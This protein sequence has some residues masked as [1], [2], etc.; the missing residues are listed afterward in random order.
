M[1]SENEDQ[2]TRFKRLIQRV[3]ISSERA[4]LYFNSDIRSDDIDVKEYRALGGVLK[5]KDSQV[6]LTIPMKLITRGGEKEILVNGARPEELLP[7][8]PLVKALARGWRWRRML[9][10]AQVKSM[11][12]LARAEGVD[13]SYVNKL[14]RLAFLPPSVIEAIL[15]GDQGDSITLAGLM[16]GDVPLRWAAI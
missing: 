15:E 11:P 5:Q 1:L 2:A 3:Q 7:N 13:M 12:A 9:E 10:T 16:Q 14:L 4:A 8:E 6:I